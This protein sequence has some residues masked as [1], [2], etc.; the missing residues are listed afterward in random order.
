MCSSAFS[1]KKQHQAA[2]ALS[3]RIEIIF[4]M[5]SNFN[6]STLF[7]RYVFFFVL[8]FNPSM[9]NTKQ[10]WWPWH[11]NWAIRLGFVWV[12][13]RNDI[14]YLQI[15]FQAKTYTGPLHVFDKFLWAV[16]SRDISQADKSI[17]RVS[18]FPK[19]FLNDKIYI[20]TKKTIWHLAIWQNWCFGQFY[21]SKIC[22]IEK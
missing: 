18:S 2:R 21:H 1:R 8:Y 10:S 3:Q 7:T 13:Y 20:Y 9:S 17:I 4:E 11:T 22:K 6:A 5:N 14:T 19:L 12:L 15:F 16:E